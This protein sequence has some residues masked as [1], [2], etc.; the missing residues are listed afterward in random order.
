MCIRDRQF[1]VNGRPIKFRGV[2]RHESHPDYGHAVPYASMLEDILL[3]KRHNIN[4]VR[5]SHYCNDPRW[6]ELCDRYGIYV[7]GEA[8]LEAHG[9]GYDDADI[10]ARNPA[11]REA[12]VDRAERMVER[13]KNHAC[14]VMW[15]LGNESGF[16]DN[17]RA[18]AE[19][20]RRRDPTRPIH[21]EGE[22]HTK[23][24]ADPRPVADVASTMYPTVDW[25]IAE[26]KKDD[27]R[28]FILCEYAHA[29]GNSPGNLKEYWEAIWAHKRLIGACV[30]EWCDH[31]IRAA[32]TADGRIIVA[33]RAKAEM[34][35]PV[36][37]FFAYGGDFGDEPHDGNFCIDGMV[38]PDRAP[39]PC[40]AE[41]KKILEPVLVEAVDALG[42][43]FRLH[44]R[45]DFRDLS[46]LEAAW[47]LMA[48]DRVLQQGLLALPSVPARSAA[49]VHIPLAAFA[50]EPGVEYRLELYFT[51]AA[52]TLWA[53]R[54]HVV[55]WS[56]FDL[57]I[58][59]QHAPAK[60]RLQTPAA[61]RRHDKAG[62]VILAGEACEFVLDMRNGCLCGCRLEGVELL[63]EPLLPN[64]WRAPTDNDRNWGHGLEGQ[65]KAHGLNRL[66]CRIE[67]VD[68]VQAGSAWRFVVESVFAAKA[69]KP[70]F[71]CRTVYTFHG[72]GEI[73]VEHVVQPRPDL[74]KLP[75]LGFR[76]AMPAGFDRVEWYGRGPHENYV[77]RKESAAVG[78]WQGTVSEQHVPY[79]RPQENGNKCD[80]RWAVSYTHLTLPTIYS[81]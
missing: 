23:N 5:T 35:A 36:P 27:P 18:M 2:N 42:G 45:H 52:D 81:V 29:M 17:H 49:E 79:V 19:W 6:F 54:G 1:L 74:P 13:D 7:I 12:F 65:W 21:Y 43:K 72:N 66:L 63:A 34:G 59:V 22:N 30:W 75:R 4:A 31:G 15:S 50:G 20:I 33:A 44:N 77:D 70:A 55:A 14:I 8:D 32:R 61:L 69:L 76:A 78:R 57:P 3:M 58:K 24:L 26:G 9:F 37:T 51:L 40:M 10:P 68:L 80:V 48:D 16:G 38:F 60:I 28:P 11:W 47:R 62:Q 39:H 53:K 46:Y 64:F 67:K 71:R 56:Q 25:F 73:L 41:Y